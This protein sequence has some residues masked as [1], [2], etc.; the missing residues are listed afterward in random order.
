[1]AVDPE[2]LELLVCPKSRGELEL[3]EL[4]SAVAS[5][6][7]ERYKEHFEEEEPSVTQGLLCRESELLYPIVADIPVMLIEEALPASILEGE[8]D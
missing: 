5:R 8:V 7:V 6:L 3:V 2:L 4:P 1:M